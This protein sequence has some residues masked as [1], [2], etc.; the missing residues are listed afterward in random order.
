MN[1][2]EAHEEIFKVA[3]TYR[4]GAKRGTRF[5][6]HGIRSNTKTGRSRKH[7]PKSFTSSEAYE[8]ELLARWH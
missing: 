8:L 5:I 6:Y 2:G 4:S 3:G 7:D 1:K